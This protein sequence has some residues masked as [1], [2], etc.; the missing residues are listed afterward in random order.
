MFTKEL[1]KGSTEL[2][3]LA[4]LEER[5]RYGYEVGKLIE[6]LSGG[7]LTFRIGSLYPM[8]T[9]LEARAAGLPVHDIETLERAKRVALSLREQLE[10]HRRREAELAAL[11]QTASDLGKAL[12]MAVESAA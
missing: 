2:L 11:F 4:L 5:P 9:R 12:A 3:I 7:R 6:R 10:A 1:K 8:F